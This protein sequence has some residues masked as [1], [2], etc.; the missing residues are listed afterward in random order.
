MKEKISTDEEEWARESGLSFRFLSTKKK[1]QKRRKS[2]PR[3]SITSNQ[4]G[5]ATFFSFSRFPSALARQ[6][7]RLPRPRFRLR[8]RFF[9]AIRN[10]RRDGTRCE[11]RLLCVVDAGRPPRRP[12]SNLSRHCS[13]ARH[14]AP[15]CVFHPCVRRFVFRSAAANGAGRERNEGVEKQ[16]RGGGRIWSERDLCKISKFSSARSKQ[17]SIRA[18]FRRSRHPSPPS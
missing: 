6:P 15:G 1:R 14:L 17:N 2:R 13:P 18:P 11:R 10:G 7:S 3:R 8:F 5:F 9:P 16:Y 12:G 4:K